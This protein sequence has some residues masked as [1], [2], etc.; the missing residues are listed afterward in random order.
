MNEN[1]LFVRSGHNR[2]LLSLLSFE[3]RRKQVQISWMDAN[4]IWVALECR[5]TGGLA[6]LY[7]GALGRNAYFLKR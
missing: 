5:D 4:L 7:R 2:F 3:E 6:C 1:R